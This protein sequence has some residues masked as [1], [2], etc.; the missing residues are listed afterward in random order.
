[1]LTMLLSVVLL[2]VVFIAE[3]RATQC[4]TAGH[5]GDD[6]VAVDHGPTG[7]HSAVMSITVME[8]LEVVLYS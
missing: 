7:R 5:K 4:G 1:M 6:N 2:V 8:L 3:Y